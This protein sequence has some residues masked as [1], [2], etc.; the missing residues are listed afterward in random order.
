[1]VHL[2]ILDV[3]MP[4]MDG[5]KAYDEIKK[6]QP[7]VKVLF[8]S[9]YAADILSVKGIID[10]GFDF[11]EKPMSPGDMLNKVRTLLDR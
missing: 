1:M 10:G 5:K 2:V 9:G 3:I 11:I 6:M 4:R 7:D 8:A